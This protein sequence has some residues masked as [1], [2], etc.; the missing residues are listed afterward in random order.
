VQVLRATRHFEIKSE[1]HPSR[2]IGLVLLLELTFLHRAFV[3]N[4]A[5]GG[6]HSIPKTEIGPASGAL[7]VTLTNAATVNVILV[8]MSRRFASGSIL[9]AASTKMGRLTHH[10]GYTMT[11][12]VEELI[13]RAERPVTARLYSGSLEAY[14]GAE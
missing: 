12:L 4:N 1:A 2:S 9:N 6:N 3:L 14:Y 10:L 5:L 11:T 7:S 8:S 13:E